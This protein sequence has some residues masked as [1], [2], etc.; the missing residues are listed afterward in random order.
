MLLLSTQSCRF[1]AKQ[2][3]AALSYAGLIKT[4]FSSSQIWPPWS[5]GISYALPGTLYNHVSRKSAYYRVAARRFGL[6]RCF[7]AAQTEE[8]S[9]HS[10]Q[11]PSRR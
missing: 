6:L 5:P 1:A 3:R 7:E 2:R 8:V 11:G 9:G 4:H 10:T